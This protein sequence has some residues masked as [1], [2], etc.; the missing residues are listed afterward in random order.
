[1]SDQ[2]VDRALER[3]APTGRA[4]RPVV[5]E[6]IATAIKGSLHPVRPLPG[7]WLLTVALLI[8]GAAV[9][10]AG[11]ARAGLTGLDARRLIVLLLLVVLAGAVA[12]DLVSRWI[13]GS[14]HYLAPG[15]L[16]VLVCAAL[17][18]AFG[19]LFDD[20]RS[21]RFLSSGIVCLSIGVAHAIPA[22]G[23]AAW[24]LRRGLA[25]RPAAAGALAGT[26][27]GLSGVAMLELHCPNLE[28]PH[29]LVWH[30][31][32]VPVSAGLGALVG[33]VLALRARRLD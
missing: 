4:V 2:E 22:A 3:L 17:L 18:L 9:A 8:L 11:A 7:P 14:R 25:L 33:W 27:G 13:P 24:L 20:Y 28:A 19:V 32:V 30:V 12:R 10:F 16:V 31:A 26:L 21:E 23:L 29:L 6:R 15:A 5:L 1:M